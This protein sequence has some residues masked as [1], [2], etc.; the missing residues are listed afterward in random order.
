MARPTYHAAAAPEHV[1]LICRVC[2]TITEVPPSTVAPLVDE[3]ERNEGFV[4]DVGHLTV[5]GT[6]A[7]C[8]QT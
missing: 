6:C 3:L 5:F 1:H 8:R 2:G 7:N 4:A